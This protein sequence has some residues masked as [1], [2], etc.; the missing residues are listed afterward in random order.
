MKD[1]FK[2]FDKMVNNMFNV[3][4]FSSNCSIITQT[5]SKGHVT[6]NGKR[7]DLP[8]GTQDV[9][10]NNGK[11]FVNGKPFDLMKGIEVYPAEIHIDNVDTLEGSIQGN[12]TIQNVK[13]IGSLESTSG[14]IM[15]AKVETMVG[16]IDTVSGNVTVGGDVEGDIDTTSGDVK[17]SGSVSGDVDTVSGDITHK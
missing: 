7:Y 8:A 2:G 13:S 1:F 6:V 11:V 12:V 9:S 4:G 14:N 3:G 10:I 16:D 15:I 5:G 17:V